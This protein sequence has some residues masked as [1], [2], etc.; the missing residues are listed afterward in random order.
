MRSQPLG[1]IA[2]SFEEDV[3][4]QDV[5]RP[6]AHRSAVV[7]VGMVEDDR[8]SAHRSDRLYEMRTDAIAEEAGFAA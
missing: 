7:P 2:H 3:R 1:S 4:P 5:L 6:S 8:T